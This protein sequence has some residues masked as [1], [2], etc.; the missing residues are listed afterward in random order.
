MKVSPLAAGGTP[1]T[2]L[3]SVNIGSSVNAG[4]KAAAEAAFLGE[5]PVTITESDTYVDPQVKK[6]L[7][8]VRKIKMRTNASPERYEQE[9]QASQEAQPAAAAAPVLAED[10][11]AVSGDNGQV[12]ATT[13]DTKPLSPQFAALAKQRRALQVKER[14]LA[15]RE[16][17][18][19]SQP[20]TNAGWI[21][22]AQL[23]SKPLSVLQEHGV[24]YDQLTEAILANQG[25]INP[26]IQALKAEI[27]ALKEGV[28]NTFKS[29][30]ESAEEGALTE[31]LFEAE[32]LAK[33]G[34]AYE[35]IRER[36]AYD[37]VLRL[38]HSTYKK[39]G[40][41]LNV[42]DAMATIET[43][44]LD[45]SFKL[46]NINKVKNKLQPIQPQVQQDQAA[47]KQ[48]RTLT[49]R[50]TARPTMSAKARALAAFNG[51][52]KK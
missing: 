51:T 6:A 35:M 25:G 39:T 37:K 30:Q 23:K 11:S 50:D 17:A 27:K 42:A 26:E 22:P 19:S 46:A 7:E 5:A 8:S 20:A 40:R 9:A 18:L 3:G 13:E 33:E 38:I 24:T 2:N 41:V 49:N 48:M 14:E 43:Q 28:D 52:L 44:L 36:N 29:Q 4:K 15:D 1:G 21:D 47:T 31:M 45:E 12:N 34:D 32:S 10:Q 16:K